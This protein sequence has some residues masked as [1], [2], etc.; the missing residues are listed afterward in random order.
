MQRFIDERLKPAED[1]LEETDDVPAEIVAD[2]KEMGLFGISIP[3]NYGGIGLSMSQ[4]C[5]V[6]Y[7]PATPPSPSARCSA[8]MSA[9]VRRAS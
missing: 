8:P 5:D 2:M 7:D 1:I 4:E 6:V 9:S 3:E